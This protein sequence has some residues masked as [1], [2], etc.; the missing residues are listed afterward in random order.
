VGLSQVP[1]SSRLALVDG[2]VHLDEERAVFEAMLA[3]R[4]RQQRSRM[5]GEA[6][7]RSRERLVRRF[8]E[9][10]ECYPWAWMPS[11]L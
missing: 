7:V 2:V 6:T 11:D 3:G 4:E 10:A 9:F 1:G 5:L 8:T